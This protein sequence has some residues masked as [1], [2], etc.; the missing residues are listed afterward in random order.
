MHRMKGT[1][2][3]GEHVQRNDE[4]AQDRLRDAGEPARE[5][6]EAPREVGGRAHLRARAG[7]EQGRQ[8]LHL[9][10]RPSVRQRPHPHRPR[11]QQDPQGLREQVPCAARLLHAVR[12]GLGL[13]RP[14]H[15]AHGGEDPRAREDGEDRPAHAAPPVPR[16]GR[17]VRRRAA[18]GLQASR[19]ERRLGPSVPHLHAELRG[20]QRRGVQEDVPRRLGVPRPQAHPLVQA[21]PHRARRGRDRV[22]RRDVAVHLREVQDGPHARDVRGRGRRGRRLRA[23][24]DHHALDAAGQHGRVAG[25]RRRLRHGGRRRLQHDHG[26][27]ARGAGGRDRGLGV[28]RSRARRGRRARLAQGPRVHGPH[29]HVSHPP[30]PQGDYHLRRP[31]HARLGHGRGAY[32]PRPRPGRLPG[33]PRVRR[34]AAHA[35]GR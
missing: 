15:R 20:G 19:R 5:R 2:N 28:L 3:R 33:R 32:R 30:G 7:E 26:A 1:H 12:A 34:A 17:E 10:R 11:L 16:V 8:A 25:P 24:L 23:H 27:R 14:A 29:L 18:R 4:P 22:L 6:A 21:L 9:A 13:P 31:R 35:G